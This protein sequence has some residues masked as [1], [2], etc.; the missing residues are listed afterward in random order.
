[1]L[2]GLLLGAGAGAALGSFAGPF[3]ALGIPEKEAKHYESELRA[4]RTVVVVRTEDQ[5]E[6][7]LTILRLHEPLSAGLV[8]EHAAQRDA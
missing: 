1:M 6:K 7:S 8:E 2:A 4:G 5:Q 3:L